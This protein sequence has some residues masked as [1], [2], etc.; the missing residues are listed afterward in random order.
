M[1]SNIGLG[2]VAD[3]A[4]TDAA[5]AETVWSTLDAVTNGL[6]G[7]NEIIGGIWVLLVSI[8]ALR[9]GVFPRTLNYLGLVSAAAGIVT[10]VPALEATGM[11]FGLG[12]IVWFSWL[13]IVLLR[14][15]QTA[16]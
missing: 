10:I 13:G 4:E 7:G 11:V 5:R 12:L 16:A 8:A 14:D 9:A 1:I 6:G 15:R 3:L 2:A